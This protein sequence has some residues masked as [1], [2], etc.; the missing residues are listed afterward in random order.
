MARKS[1]CPKEDIMR[2]IEDVRLEL[3]QW[4]LGDWA[5]AAFWAILIPAVL[6]MLAKVA[7]VS[8]LYGS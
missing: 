7:V 4:S 8:Y 6:G 1:V 3:S 2:Y 5:K